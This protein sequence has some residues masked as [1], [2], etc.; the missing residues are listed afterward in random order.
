MAEGLVRRIFLAAFLAAGLLAGGAARVDTA[1]ADTAQADTAQAD[2]AQADTAV[3]PSEFIAGLG[4]RAVSALTGPDLSRSEREARFRELLDSHFDVPAIGKFVLGR[5]WRV[6]TEEEKQE[7]LGLFEE[8]LIKG[9][10]R[11]FAEYSG[12]T[13]EVRNVRQEA[14]G[15]SLVQSLVIRPSAENVRVDWR[16]QGTSE[17]SFRIID[18]IVEGLSMAATQRDEFA[19]VIQ[20]KGGKVAGLIEVLRQKVGQGG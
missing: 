8:F 13:F 5:Y 20:S 15:Q 12:E 19:S 16:V 6:A 7:F 1:Q 10:A 11:R 4:D 18:V 14:G 3:S 9:Y 17:G 2:T